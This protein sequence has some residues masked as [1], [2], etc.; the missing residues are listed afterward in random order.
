MGAGQGD[1]SDFSFADSVSLVFRGCAATVRGSCRSRES[2]L[3]SHLKRTPQAQ[4]QVVSISTGNC[5]ISPLLRA[6]TSLVSS[7][8]R[9]GELQVLLGRLEGR[10][11]GAAARNNGVVPNK[12]RYG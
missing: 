6:V 5:P 9:Q 12:N 10:W 4:Q 8:R 7:F 1:G 3:A 2:V 11:R